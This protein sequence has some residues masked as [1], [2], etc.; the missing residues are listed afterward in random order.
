MNEIERIVFR[1]E[2]GDK[3]GTAFLIS[4]HLA[5]TAFHVVD[6]HKLAPITLSHGSVTSCKAKLSNKIDTK[7]KALDVALLELETN[8]PYGC[9]LNFV[10]FAVIPKGIRWWSR[11]FPRAKIDDGDNILEKETNLTNQQLPSLHNGKVDMHLE[12]DQKLSSY[13]GYSGAPLIVNDAIAG[14]INSEMGDGNSKELYALSL[15]HF[16][17]LL[18]SED[19]KVVVKQRPS[20][21][22]LLNVLTDS[23]FEQQVATS[24]KN[25]GVRYTAELNLALDIA[26]NFDFLVK[27]EAAKHHIKTMFHAFLVKV[28]IATNRLTKEASQKDIETLQAAIEVIEN[29]HEK[30]LTTTANALDITLLQQKIGKIATVLSTI[31][32]AGIE[33]D[34][35]RL[36]V[37]E[38]AQSAVNE[39]RIAFYEFHE[40]LKSNL[41]ALTN[42][43]QMLITGEA[44]IGKS[45]LLADI[46]KNRISAGNSCIFLLGQHFT[47]ESPPW[48]QILQSLLRLDCNEEELLTLLNDLGELQG[49]RVLFIIDAINEGRGRYFWPAHIR[50]FINSFK[51]YP[52]IGLVLSV[53]SSYEALLAPATLLSIQSV[54]KI[55]HTGFRSKEFEATSLFFENYGIDLPSTPLLNPE[56]ANPLF[57]KLFC[58]GLTRR[59]LHKVPKGYGGISS[60]IDF[61]ITSINNK[62]AEPDHFDYPDH[63]QV[64]RKVINALIKF[65][66]NRKLSFIPYDEANDIATKELSR[67]SDKRRFLDALIDEGMLSKNLFRPG[68]NESTPEEGVYFAYERFDD[69]WATAHLLDEHLDLNSPLLAFKSGGELGAYIVDGD[70]NRGIIESLSIQLPERIGMELYE[71][72]DEDEVGRKSIVEPFIASLLWRKQETIT[73]KTSDFVTDY[74]LTNK[75][76]FA[77]FIDMIYGVAADPRHVYNADYLHRYLWSFSMADRDA[78]WTIYLNNTIANDGAIVRLVDWALRNENQSNLS[79]QSIVLL[80]KAIAWLFTSTNIKF[81]DTATKAL[82]VLLEN[83]LTVIVEF[84]T[85]FDQVNDPYVYERIFAAI[86]GA[87][88]RSDELAGLVALSLYIIKTIFEKE[89]VYPNVL[90]RDFARNIVEYAMYKQLIILESPKII[91]PP[92]KSFFPQSFPS[93]KV[94]DSYKFDFNDK[95]FKEHNWGQNKILSSM[96][97]TGKRENGHYGDF[98]RYTFEY[99]VSDWKKFSPNELSNYAC[100]LIFE[101]YGYD[102]EKHGQFDK[103]TNSLDRHRKNVER[104]GKKYQWIALYEVQAR[105]AD[106]HKMLDESTGWGCEKAYIHY[107]GPWLNGMRDIDPTMIA[108]NI[109]DN[110]MGALVPMSY[111]DWDMTGKEWLTSDKRL[112]DP[113]EII[114]GND[115]LILE[116]DNRWQ[117]PVPLGIDNSD[118]SRKTLW[119]NISSYLVKENEFEALVNWLGKEHFMD[120]A[121]PQSRDGKSV[122]CREFYWSPAYKYL[123]K[124]YYYGQEWHE[125]CHD[126]QSE[127]VIASIMPTAERHLW[128]AP[129]D[130]GNGASHLAPRPMMYEGLNLQYSKTPGTWRSSDDRVVCYDP[131]VVHGGKSALIVNKSAFQQYL[132]ANKLKVVWTC[133]GKKEIHGKQLDVDGPREWLELSGVYTLEDDV[134]KGHLRPIVK[135]PQEREFDFMSKR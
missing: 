99:A 120:I 123:D 41:L 68:N 61:F 81:R 65:K 14:I 5:L 102:V 33:R 10:D 105:L 18:E 34:E 82:V 110:D 25:L 64:V 31:Q 111:N 53:R 131:S 92:Y 114:D 12:H 66:L 69:H 130:S 71:L 126:R 80:G 8:M 55:V 106:N 98:G 46:A 63:R 52:W 118:F 88:L 4:E 44:G 59:G 115:F 94:I 91:R 103:T 90:V 56:F 57:L 6:E 21:S 73:E 77:I 49:E 43:P 116:H 37:S 67:Y 107:P 83:K 40:F 125:I 48:S 23:W 124:P 128:E 112:P 101:Q 97:T 127:E 89:E 28:N 62:L 45:H 36:A 122:F 135:C 72:L 2:C 134:V 47:T 27:N 129:E 42:D 74:V 60:I 16:K 58:E 95:N 87:V 86:Y 11:G 84:L 26:K 15:Q 3:K 9:E 132:T 51:K 39:A 54:T 104:I 70:Q 29:Q 19:I 13:E 79:N 35:T 1:V 78:K 117:Q 93:N 121:L 76:S 119:Y 75:H 20:T 38:Y 96:V 22:K 7:Y 85:E 30:I 50:G 108:A 133:L 100:K 17:I 109:H 24:V 32:D 113:A